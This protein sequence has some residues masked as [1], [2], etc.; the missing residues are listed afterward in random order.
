MIGVS[1]V[2]PPVDRVVAGVPDRSPP[3]R[4]AAALLTLIATWFTSNEEGSGF[5]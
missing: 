1:L 4:R 2:L 3:C 5:R